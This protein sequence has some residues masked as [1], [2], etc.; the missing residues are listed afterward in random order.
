MAKKEY[1]LADLLVN[2]EK[3]IQNEDEITYKLIRHIGNELPNKF[4]AEQF[5]RYILGMVE[6]L[7]YNPEVLPV[8]M[9][10]NRTRIAFKMGIILLLLKKVATPTFC[11]E[12]ERL[13]VKKMQ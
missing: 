8:W 6:K 13:L 9:Q 1:I 10:Q 7:A 5:V 12:C 4:S 11:D 3:F 2:A